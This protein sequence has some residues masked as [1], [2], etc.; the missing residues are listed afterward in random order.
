[1][2][3]QYYPKEDLEIILADG[4]SKDRI[5]VIVATYTAK[6]PFIRLIDNPNS[7]ASWVKNTGIKG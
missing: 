5:R 1:M 7:I 3:E 2:L 6:Y 4:M